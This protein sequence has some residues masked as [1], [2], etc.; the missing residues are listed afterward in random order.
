MSLHDTDTRAADDTAPRSVGDRELGWLL[1]VGGLIGLAAALV[2]TIDKLRLQTDPSYQPSCNLSATINCGSVMTSKQ[3]SVFGFPNSFIGLGAFAVLVL[4]GI[5]LLARVRFDGWFWA[6]VQ[7]GVL[8][9]IGFVG[10]LISQSLYEIGALCP[11]CMAVWTV[12]IA[13]FVVVTLRNLAEHT[14]FATTPAGAALVRARWLVVVALWA[15][16]AVLVLTR[17]A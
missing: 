14:G 6:G 13:L 9:G 12:T 11:Y 3:A 8:F 17:F 10:W 2:L 16:V 5:A 7:A 15:V 1:V 4:I